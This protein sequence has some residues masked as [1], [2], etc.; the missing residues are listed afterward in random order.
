M[1]TSLTI[2]MGLGAAFWGAGCLLLAAGAL[3][4]ERALCGRRPW[5]VYWGL[6]A[7]G[8]FTGLLAGIWW[9]HR[10]PALL[11]EG[12]VQGMLLSVGGLIIIDYL[13]FRSLGRPGPGASLTR[14]LIPATG[15]FILGG[16]VIVAITRSG[17][18]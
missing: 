5:R 1:M 11:R 16:I 9:L 7:P 12:L 3:W 18:G 14:A 10:Q 4:P 15:A 6:I 2:A 17:S 8:A 13:C